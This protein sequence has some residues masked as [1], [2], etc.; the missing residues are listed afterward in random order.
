MRLFSLQLPLLALTHTVLLLYSSSTPS[1][2]SVLLRSPVHTLVPAVRILAAPAPYAGDPPANLIAVIDA[3]FAP[4]Q[5]DLIQSYSEIFNV[6]HLVLGYTSREPKSGQTYY[7]NGSF[8]QLAEA[9]A[10]VLKHFVW[11]RVSVAVDSSEVAF[12]VGRILRTQEEIAVDEVGFYTPAPE[13]VL[14]IV[15]R[16]LRL[17][18]NRVTVLLTRSVISQE[19]ERSQG[20]QQVSGV[21]YANLLPLL[22]GLYETEPTLQTGSLVLA[23]RELEGA[24]TQ[25]EFYDGMLRNALD[26]V[27]DYTDALRLKQKLGLL[28]PDRI[29]QPAYRLLNVQNG[30]RVLVGNVGNGTMTLTEQVVFLGNTTQV[31][32]QTKAALTVSANF[33]ARNANSIN[34]IP[35]LYYKGAVLALSQVNARVDILPNFVLDLLNF[36]AGVQVWNYQFALTNLS[37]LKPNLGLAILSAFGSEVS[38]NFYQLMKDLNITKALVGASNTVDDLSST[39]QFPTYVR[40]VVPDKYTAAAFVQL[41][42]HFGWT[43]CALM[44]SDDL[45]GRKFREA[46]LAAAEANRI[47]VLN[48]ED[49]QI[50]P[51][52]LPSVATLRNCTHFFQNFIDSRAKV[53]IISMIDNAV[54]VVDYLYELGLRGGDVQFIA[55]KWLSPSLVQTNDSYTNQVRSEMLQGAVQLLL[56]GFVGSFGKQVKQDFVH[57]FSQQPDMRSCFF[58]DAALAVA[59]AADTCV[60]MGKDYTD[61]QVFYRMIKDSKFVGCSGLVY[62]SS[63]TND[64][65]SMSYQIINSV[66]FNS[67]LNVS[68]VGIY[69]PA[70]P[71]MFRFSQQL[72]WCDGSTNVPTAVRE[73]TLGCPFEDRL[74]MQ[75]EPGESLFYGLAAGMFLFCLLYSLAVW[76]V[77]WNFPVEELLESREMQFLDIFAFLG[78]IIEALQ[79][80][81]LGPSGSFLL[82]ALQLLADVTALDF[83]DMM[84]Y[85]NGGFEI[86]LISVYAVVLSWVLMV[87]VLVCGLDVKLRKLPG[88]HLFGEVCE[89]VVPLINDWL[90]LPVFSVLFDVFICTDSVSASSFSASYLRSDCYIACWQG[91]HTLYASLSSVCMCVF[92]LIAT[93][94]RPL[95]QEVQLHVNIK[96]GRGFL[97]RKCTVQIFIVLLNKTLKKAYPVVY[98]SLFISLFSLLFVYSFRSKS[99]NYIRAQFW[100]K[101][102]LGAVLWTCVMSILQSNTHSEGVM[103]VTLTLFGYLALVVFGLGYQGVRL[104]SYLYSRSGVDSTVLF[105]FAFQ[106]TTSDI[107]TELRESFRKAGHRNEIR[108]ADTSANTER[109]MASAITENTENK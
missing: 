28:F 47:S 80:I 57:R 108:V 43:S 8:R 95:W 102:A 96:A 71:V 86:V 30:R 109:R 37:P 69:D 93:L 2:L 39:A 9:I 45:S 82:F 33:G 29:R 103:W 48:D 31:P 60:Q 61:T 13:D 98:Q 36:T 70:S 66:S 85:L 74:N 90:Y 79:Y 23:E 94:L 35:Q 75:F 72:R 68:L 105:R 67:S 42:A 7:V 63:A 34:Y 104:P 3:T 38:V 17:T 107:L 26:I 52:P 59:Y 18:G 51:S 92:L 58:Y 99:Y 77:F 62:F 5:T 83:H 89:F 73:S 84:L 16:E 21:G 1:Q 44:V 11:T 32:L 40:T 46:F 22:S 88:A 41:F 6:P 19:I 106:R 20:R 76:R 24:N 81:S 64:R 49:M 53:L 25:S 56:N 14:N 4:S 78:I 50:F 65:A 97:M 100:H 15:G 87:T 54:L 12:N 27:A 10:L 101:V 55:N 91:N